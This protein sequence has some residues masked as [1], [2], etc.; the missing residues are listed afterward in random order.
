MEIVKTFLIGIA[1]GIANV[2]PGFSG[3]TMAV[4]FNIYDKF[5]DTLSLNIKRLIANWKFVVPLLVGMLL[6]V[7][8]FSSIVKYLYT[9][10]PDQTNFV[11]TCILFGSIPMLY[12]Y[13]VKPSNSEDKKRRIPN[14]S[15]IISVIIG[16]A[17]M[18]GFYYLQQKYNVEAGV[19]KELPQMTV[20]LGIRIFIAGLLGAIAMIIP[21]ISGSFIMLILGIYPIVIAAIAS[22]VIPST[23]VQSL[24]IL[25]PNGIGVILG[26]VFGS[27]LV[28]FLIKHFPNQTYGVIFGLVVG[29][30]PIMFPGFR[31]WT[32]AINVIVSIICFAGGF[33]LAVFGSKSSNEQPS[34]ESK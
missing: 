29:S 4:V 32:S 33:A 31:I 6:G 17:I 2:I 5:V 11:F 30:V 21:G 7:L 8:F 25:L 1:I 12:M 20:V 18:I 26:L 16:F 23:F 28:S 14:A 27:K 19:V 24:L 10:F 22:I 34:Q 13:I 15:A 9:N 3:G